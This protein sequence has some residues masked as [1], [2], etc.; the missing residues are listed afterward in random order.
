ML[1]NR[2]EQKYLGLPRNPEPSSPPKN[3]LLGRFSNQDK[4]WDCFEHYIKSQ[5]HTNSPK[6]DIIAVLEGREIVDQDQ[7]IF[8][9]MQFAVTVMELKNVCAS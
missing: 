8:I 4:F 5:I 6:I 2:P 9:V 3:L 7:Q 1:L